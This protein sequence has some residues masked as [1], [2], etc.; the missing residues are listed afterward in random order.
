ML[1][2]GCDLLPKLG[3]SPIKSLTDQL[4]DGNGFKLF[5]LFAALGAKCL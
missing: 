1:A 2:V 4:P 3:L 5:N